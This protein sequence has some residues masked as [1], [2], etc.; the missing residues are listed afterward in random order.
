MVFLI[1]DKTPTAGSITFL[2]FMIFMMWIIA[3]MVNY[4]AVNG[5]NYACQKLSNRQ[6][7]DEKYTFNIFTMLVFFI[8]LYAIV[9]DVIF[10]R[11]NQNTMIE[12]V[13]IYP[14]A[15]LFS[16]RLGSNRIF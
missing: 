14:I 10:P 3:R 16:L 7:L 8:T 6:F 1:G 4:V 9:L 13:I 2:I 11:G 15:L 12:P 5:I